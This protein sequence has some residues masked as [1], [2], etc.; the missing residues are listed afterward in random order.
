MSNDISPS[1]SVPLE[2][3]INDPEIQKGIL[4]VYANEPFSYDTTTR[5]YELGRQI[6]ILAKKHGFSTRGS[7]LRKKPNSTQMAIVRTKLS[8]V[9]HIIHELG[10]VGK[11]L[12]I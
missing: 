10:F 11:Q 3:W 1:K 2:I 4:A 8:I 12:G 5:G 6:A 7:I 9:L